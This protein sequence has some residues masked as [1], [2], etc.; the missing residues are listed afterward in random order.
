MIIGLT[1]KNASGKGEVAQVLK[2]AGFLYLSL[3]DLLREELRRRGLEVIRENLIRVGNEMRTM[4]GG[5]Y[6]ADRAL[7][8]IDVDKNYIVDSIRNPREVEVLRRLHNFKLVHVTAVPQVRFER[9]KSR[10][11]EGDPKNF[12]EF[13][14][15]EVREAK[16]SDPN[17]QQLEATGRL[18][19]AEIENNSTLDELR[20][21]V[22]ELVLRLAQDTPRPSWDAYFMGIAQV[23]ALR[24]NCL[25][26]KVAAVIVRDRRIISTGYNGTPRGITNCNEGGCP[27]CNSFGQS[28]VGLEECY[29]SHAEEN[30]ITQAA[31]H[32]VPIK[33]GTLY[34]TFSPCLICTKMIIN[35]GIV[36]VVYNAQ[37]PM[38]EQPIVLLK[39]AGIA[40]RQVELK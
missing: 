27:R 38:A 13:Q 12:A 22:R 32:G 16:S 40:V 5:G 25:K 36:E 23:V 31:Y 34:T 15:L 14:E 9:I 2:E 33:G 7:Q 17:T 1:G 8:A 30:S 24:S 26:R 37:Y 20:G 6:L 29:C 28:G 11:R 4:Y 18:A 10:A 21:K 19:D 3:S 35:S 39:E